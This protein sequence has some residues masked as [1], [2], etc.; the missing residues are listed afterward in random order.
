MKIRLMFLSFSV[1]MLTTPFAFA[2]HGPKKLLRHMKIWSQLGVTGQLG[3]YKIN[4]AV[5]GKQPKEKKTSV[6][7][8]R[9][10]NIFGDEMNLA[11]IVM[12][13]NEIIYER[14]N[15]KNGFDSNTP[16][17]G[18]SM[19]KTAAA[20]S[21]ATLQCEGKIRSLDDAA[22]LYSPFLK[23]TP[24][25]DIKISNI[26]QMNSGVSPIGRSDEMVF[27]HQSRGT[28]KKYSGKASV[29][30]TLKIYSSA[31][32]TEGEK[33]NYHSSDALALSVL[34]EEASGMP[35]SEFFFQNHYAKF[36]KSDYMQWTGDTVGTTVSF[37]ELTMTARDWANFGKYLMD[38]IKVQ[39]CLGSYFRDGIVKAVYTG[40]KNGSKYGYQSWV[41]DV[42][43]TPTM[44]LQGHGGQFMVLNT[45]TNTLL[46]LISISDKYKAGNLFNS[47]NKL[48]E[49]LH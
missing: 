16:L 20:A 23:T 43:G 38:E 17:M 45:K 32:R 8:K 35:L 4:V 25:A 42:N 14:Y 5:F 19:S 10:D 28:S 18:M 34:V 12:K 6:D 44:T 30:N 7:N 26:L 27:N 41:F 47:I 40:K 2:D 15:K 46:L 29:R 39:S 1:V 36:G 9:F 37:S 11:A 21:V 13:G 3:P 22:G 31:A 24:Y 48:A 49:N 33:M